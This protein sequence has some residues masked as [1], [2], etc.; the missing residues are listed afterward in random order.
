MVDLQPKLFVSHN[1][2]KDPRYNVYSRTCA[3]NLRKQPIILT[4]KEKEK[5]DLKHPNSY[6][7]AIKYGTGEK[8]YWYICP[9]Y[10]SIKDNVSLTE[11]EAKSGNYGKIIPP[12][13]KVLKD[14][15]NVFEFNSS[16]HKDNKTGKYKYLSPGFLSSD[17]HPDGLCLPCCYKDWDRKDQVSRRA[18]CSNTD[19]PI[20][21]IEAKKTNDDY[22]K[23]PEKFPLAPKRWGFLPISVQKLLRTNNKECQMSATNITL[24]PD[25]KCLLR[26]GVEINRL[27]SFIACIASAYVDGKGKMDI[28][29]IKQMKDIIIK[30]INLDKFITYQNGS[31]LNIFYKDIDINNTDNRD[32]T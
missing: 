32:I 6:K 7:N 28:P 4:D 20:T 24:K 29:T 16:Y 9:R 15:E 13:A 17:K 5:I 31:L 12:K 3:W 8:K 25:H 10:W 1:K 22:I 11:E 26:Y 19:K 21:D 23:G 18:E 14:G 27:Q 2:N 30:S